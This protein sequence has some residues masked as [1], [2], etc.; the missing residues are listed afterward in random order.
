MKRIYVLVFSLLC[1]SV[2]AQ[3]VATGFGWWGT[4]SSGVKVTN[5]FPT[6]DAACSALAAWYV[7]GGTNGGLV[8]VN[9][10]NY[11]CNINVPAK[12]GSA[13]YLWPLPVTGVAGQTF[14]LPCP[15]AGTSGIRNFTMGYSSNANA[16]TEAITYPSPTGTMGMVGG[17][18][19]CAAVVGFWFVGIFCAH[20]W[21]FGV[22]VSALGSRCA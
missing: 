22:G 1:S 7:A 13:A 11:T 10:S 8:V 21:L 3:G 19:S 16:G 2:F 18:S 20:G 5:V 14:S 9:A 12:N 6:A 4:N 15:A 17:G